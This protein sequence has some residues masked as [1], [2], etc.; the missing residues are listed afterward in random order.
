M[1]QCQPTLDQTE[2]GV[3]MAAC[4]WQDVLSARHCQR[5]ARNDVAGGCRLIRGGS[6][7][8]GN[9][10]RYGIFFQNNSSIEQGYKD[11]YVTV[12]MKILPNLPLVAPMGGIPQSLVPWCRSIPDIQSMYMLMNLYQ[13]AHANGGAW[14]V[15]IGNPC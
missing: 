6:R 15:S 7:R 14:L 9:S 1:L 8:L 13:V 4:K 12:G 5:G 11:R 2:G 10:R 3:L